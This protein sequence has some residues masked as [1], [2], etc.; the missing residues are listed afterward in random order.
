[1][2]HTSIRT[3]EMIDFDNN[4][5]RLFKKFLNL[6]EEVLISFQTR[7]QYLESEIKWINQHF[8][9]LIKDI[10]L[11]D[12]RKYKKSLLEMAISELELLNDYDDNDE[13]KVFDFIELVINLIN[14]VRYLNQKEDDIKSYFV[15]NENYERYANL[16]KGR[17]AS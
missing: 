3:Y 15:S 12:Q 16:E 5:D 14:K 11:I 6:A 7:E 10:S 17:V 4:K 13:D 9:S 8:I 1:M 2:N